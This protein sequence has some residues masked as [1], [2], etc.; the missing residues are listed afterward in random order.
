[1]AGKNLCTWLALSFCWTHWSKSDLH[2]GELLF[3]AVEFHMGHFVD[4]E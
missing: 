2:Q 3:L 4:V 1:M